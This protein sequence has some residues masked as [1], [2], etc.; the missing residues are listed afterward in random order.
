MAQQ[1]ICDMC[2]N[3]QAVMMQSD[4]RDGTTI[5]V[6]SAC[7]FVYFYNAAI[8]AAPEGFFDT[9][10]DGEAP[11]EETPKRKRAPRKTQPQPVDEV[12]P[13]PATEPLPV[14]VDGSGD[15]EPPF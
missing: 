5:A 2:E 3:E 12:Q 7:L 13:L 8:G 9:P 11:K 14:G 6:G 4:L 1:V 10:D 15:D